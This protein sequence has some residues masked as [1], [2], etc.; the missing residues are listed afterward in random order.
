MQGHGSSQI[1]LSPNKANVEPLDDRFENFLGYL[2]IGSSPVS[3]YYRSSGSRTNIESGDRVNSLFFNNLRKLSG[4]RF[5]KKI[6]YQI[7]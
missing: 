6:M 5:R 3:G 7:L 2:A 1:L 4:S